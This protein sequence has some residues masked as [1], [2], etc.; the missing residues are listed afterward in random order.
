MRDVIAALAR[1][2]RSAL[3][4]AAQLGKQQAVAAPLRVLTRA[5]EHGALWNVISLLGWAVDRRR[6]RTWWAVGAA[7]RRGYILNQ[8]I[9]LGVRRPR[10]QLDDFPQ[11]VKTGSQRSFPSAHATTSFAAA[12]V[13]RQLLPAA[14]VYAL[15]AVVALSRPV[16]AVHYPSDSLGG[17]LLGH[18][19]AGP[20]LTE[21]EQ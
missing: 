9:K 14:P 4:L 5:G 10:P 8:L 20:V 2:D 12:R 6:A 13:L 21:L 11:A 19:T 1:L 17:A 18:L 16:F 3:A 15:A 7:A